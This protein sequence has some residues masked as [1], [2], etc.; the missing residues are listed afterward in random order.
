T[1]D[2]DTAGTKWPPDTYRTASL[3]GSA[4]SLRRAHRRRRGRTGRSA[5]I[6]PD[7]AAGPAFPLVPAPGTDPKGPWPPLPPAADSAPPLPEPR[8][9]ALAAPVETNP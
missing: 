3:R 8:L 1:A 6:S 4:A 9:P 2:R 5:C 7:P